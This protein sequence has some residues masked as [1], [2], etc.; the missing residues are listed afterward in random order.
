MKRFANGLTGILLGRTRRDASLLLQS[1]LFD[2]GFYA[3][4]VDAHEK[5]SISHFLNRGWRG[6]LSPSPYFDS[7]FYLVAYAD[8]RKDNWNPVLHYIRHGWREGRTPHPCFDVAKYIARHPHIDFG[9]ID[10]LRHCI[11]HYHSLEWSGGASNPGVPRTIDYRALAAEKRQLEALFDREYYLSMYEDV[12][13][14]GVDPFRHYAQSGWREDRNPSPEFDTW[15]FLKNFPEFANA[16]DSPLHQ[17]VRAGRPAHWKLRSPDSVTL[18]PSQNHAAAVA[19][20]GRLRLAVHVHAYYPEYIEEVHHALARISYPFDLFA[21]ACTA[22]DERFIFHYLRR[23]NPRFSVKVQ[24]V[25]NRGRDIGPMLTAFPGVWKDYDVVA[26]LHSKK[27]PHICFGDKW[28]QYALDQMFGSPE[29]L[30]SIMDYL[31][32]NEDVGFFF[33]DNYHSIKKYVEWGVCTRL[34]DS[35]LERANLP[36]VKK[37]KIAEF[38]AGSMAWFRTSAFRDLVDTFTS[39]ED[40]ELEDGQLDT[41]V[42]HAIEHVFPLFVKA[43]GFRSVC[44]YPKRRPRLRRSNQD[45]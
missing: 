6:G 2:L 33:P 13:A 41:T 22:A 20:S 38:A 27:S 44:Y 5:P 29:L 40:F 42:A 8:V 32:K 37:P 28:R 16:Q 11:E 36:K 3:S 43:Q 17:F 12:Q 26:H 39:P 25:E 19:A 31:A 21:T 24:L 15:Y 14:A 35:I 34:M 7:T 10:P 4:Q 23:R 18:D 45:M 9:L 1:G 30:E